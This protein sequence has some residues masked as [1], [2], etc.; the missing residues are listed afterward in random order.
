MSSMSSALSTHASAEGREADRG[1]HFAG[2][3]RPQLFY[4]EVRAAFRPLR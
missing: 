4:D 1:R 3:E 2:W